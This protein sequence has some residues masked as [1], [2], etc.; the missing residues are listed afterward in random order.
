[1]MSHEFSPENLGSQPLQLHG[2][3]LGFPK[4][5]LGEKLEAKPAVTKFVS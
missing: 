5:S 4:E 2:F 3:P 1:M